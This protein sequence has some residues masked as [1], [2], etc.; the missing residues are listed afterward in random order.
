MWRAKKKTCP[1]PTQPKF[2]QD[3]TNLTY[4]LP[5]VLPFSPQNEEKRGKTCHTRRRDENLEK[6][7]RERER[8][9]AQLDVSLQTEINTFTF[10]RY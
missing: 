9:R 7:K 8:E 3:L 1:D 4:F 5:H 10:L 2:F 6:M